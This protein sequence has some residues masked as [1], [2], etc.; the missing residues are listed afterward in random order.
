MYELIVHQQ[1]PKTA[2]TSIVELLND[3]FTPR[4]VEVIKVINDRKS[5][6]DVLRMTDDGQ[7]TSEVWE[8]LTQLD[9]RTSA[10]S[11]MAPWGF[12]K[13]IRKPLWC[14]TFV[15]E[16][17]SRLL[18]YWNFSCKAAKSGKES[19]APFRDADFD[20]DV[21]LTRM[22]SLSFFNEQ[23]RMIGGSGRI[24]L[25]E[26]DL[27]RAQ[28]VIS[29]EL[30]FI[31]VVE[32]F[33]ASIKTLRELLDVSS[34]AEYRLNSANG[35]YDFPLNTRQVRLLHELNEW[36]LKLYKW[37]QSYMEDIADRARKR[38]RHIA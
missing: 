37:I 8:T 22:I 32:S 26:D 28:E 12:H 29:E 36:D 14:F 30:S 10:L 34:T 11:I 7:E 19:F 17:I 5:N 16:P 24:W 3:A 25:C 9:E 6:G 1:I 4:A 33:D 35:V 38:R 2:T 23:T 20:L 27:Q 21:A 31:G 18:S 15:R 13:A